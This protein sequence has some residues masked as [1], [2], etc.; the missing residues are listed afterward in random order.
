MTTKN[1][2]L[3]AIR[4][5]CL[6]CCGGS[7]KEIEKCTVECSMKPYRFGKDQ[8]PSRINNIQKSPLPQDEFFQNSDHVGIDS[9][10]SKLVSKNSQVV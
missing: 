5:N 9:P 7:T 8:S 4:I 10:S 6:D 3:K 1:T 2:I